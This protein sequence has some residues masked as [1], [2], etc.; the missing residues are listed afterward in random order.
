[1]CHADKPAAAIFRGR[2]ESPLPTFFL[3]VKGRQS[4][5]SIFLAHRR[6]FLSSMSTSSVV[7]L[8]HPDERLER[9]LSDI[10]LACV[11]LGSV[12]HS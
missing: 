8:V 10:E 5:G 3:G 9:V 1:M 6:L 4:I 2:H 11:H 12:H 7:A